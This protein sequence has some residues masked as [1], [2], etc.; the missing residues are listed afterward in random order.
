MKKVYSP[1]N[2][3]IK[4]KL[5]VHIGEEYWTNQALR[6]WRNPTLWQIYASNFQENSKTKNSTVFTT[7]RVNKQKRIFSIFNTIQTPYYPK[8]STDIKV[9]SKRKPK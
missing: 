5:F 7:M 4:V 9:K 6:K 8:D 1:P 3:P 2:R